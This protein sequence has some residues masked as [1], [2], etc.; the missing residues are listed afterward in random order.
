MLKAQANVQ[1]EKASRYMKALCNHF[2]R[3]VTAEYNDERGTVQFG[4]GYCEMQA[5]DNALSIQI[6]AD[7]DENF[8]RVK[9]VVA[10]HLVRFGTNDELVVNWID[11]A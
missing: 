9:Y 5:D 3:K 11:E 4:F 10:D 1:T 8:E 2:N 7:T 6:Q